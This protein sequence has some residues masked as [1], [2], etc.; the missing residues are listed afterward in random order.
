M[1]ALRN[2][3]DRSMKISG[4]GEKQGA[5][6]GAFRI[7]FVGAVTVTAFALGLA[8]M[9]VRWPERFDNTALVLC[10]VAIAPWVLPF[11]SQ[12]VRSIEAFGTKITLLESQIE[13]ASRKL[14]ELYLLSLG[15]KLVR[16]LRKLSQPTGYG[17]CYVGAALPRELEYLENLGYIEFKPPLKGLDDFLSKNR[18]RHVGNLSDLVGLTDA[19]RMFYELRAGSI[20]KRGPAPA[21]AREPPEGAPEGPAE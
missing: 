20:D 7:T 11:V 5:K 9:H 2:I 19:G 8:A 17:K 14:D 13:T 1:V 15:G 18:D 21:G 3:E 10:L 4:T 12:H 16:H 6:T